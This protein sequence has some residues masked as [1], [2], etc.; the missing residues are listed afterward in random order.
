MRNKKNLTKIST[1]NP[2]N[3]TLHKGRKILYPDIEK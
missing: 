3:K 1:E 2:K